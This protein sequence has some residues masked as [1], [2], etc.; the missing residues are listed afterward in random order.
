[1]RYMKFLLFI[2]L[3][4]LPALFCSRQLSLEFF[5]CSDWYRIFIISVLIIQD[6]S[7]DLHT[8]GYVVCT[9]KHVEYPLPRQCFFFRN[10]LRCS[11][12]VQY[13]CGRKGERPPTSFPSYLR[14]SCN[15]FQFRSILHN[16]FDYVLYTRAQ[17]DALKF[18]INFLILN[19]AN[20]CWNYPDL[21][22]YNPKS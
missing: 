1:M 19:L 16:I 21:T 4:N 18:V 22:V 10:S 8:T 3:Y 15:S 17:D 12:S 13:I 14:I 6:F 9:S 2:E 11:Q 5:F 7:V 20:L